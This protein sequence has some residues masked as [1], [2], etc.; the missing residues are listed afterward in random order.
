[1]KAELHIPTEQYGFVS[2]E[3]EVPSVEDALHAYQHAASTV[4]GGEGMSE[5][6]MDLWVCNM[7]LG[8]GND[9]NVYQKATKS[10]QIELHRIK[11]AL[12]RI[13]MRQA[14][15]NK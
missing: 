4:R 13:K 1:M 9:V 7:L 6:E 8:E 11:R 3:V 10:Q 14:K 15:Q 2:V 5:E 12:N